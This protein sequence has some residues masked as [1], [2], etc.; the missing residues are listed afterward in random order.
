MGEWMTDRLNLISSECPVT[1]LIDGLMAVTD[2]IA[3]WVGEGGYLFHTDCLTACVP[4]TPE[5]CLPTLLLTD[6]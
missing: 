4:V 3:G 1:N 6:R 2:R 5:A